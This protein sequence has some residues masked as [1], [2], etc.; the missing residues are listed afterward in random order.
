MPNKLKNHL[1]TKTHRLQL[2][3]LCFCVACIAYA[4]IIWNDFTYDDYLVIVNNPYIDRHGFI[5]RCFSKEYFNISGEATYRPVVT[6]VYWFVTALFGKQAMFFHILSLCL[7]ALTTAGIVLLGYSMGLGTFSILSGIFFAFHPVLTEAVC[8][9]AFMEDVLITFFS[10]IAMG[11]ITSVRNTDSKRKILIVHFFTAVCF[12]L[13]IFSKESGIGL[14]IL[15]PAGIILSG[16]KNK[17]L[18]DSETKVF[19]RQQILYIVIWMIPIILF[20]LVVRFYL[21]AGYATAPAWLGGSFVKACLNACVIAMEYLGRL[22]YPVS[23]SLIR[24]PINVYGFT[25]PVLIIA[26]LLHICLILSCL[27]TFRDVPVWSLG[28]TWFYV[29]FAPVSNLIPFWNPVADRYL[30]MMAVGFVFA[31]SILVKEL[32]RYNKTVKAITISVIVLISSTWIEH[33]VRRVS[34][35]Q[36]NQT[37]WKKELMLHPSNPVVLAENAA[38]ANQ[39]GNY[40]EAM[41]LT[42]KILAIDPNCK[43]ARYYMGKSL[44]MRKRYNEAL[45]HYRKVLS[46]QNLQKHLYCD[47]LFDVAYMADKVYGD[48]ELAEST[49]RRSL[50]LDP[51]YLRASF[52]LG[53]LLFR[54]GK[55]D[56]ALQVWR[57]ALKFCPSHPD[58]IHNLRLTERMLQNTK[59]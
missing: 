13:A 56:E 48:V 51:A 1:N 42:S 2:A 33:T 31:L 34:D 38:V 14:T 26:L 15:L 46:A 25:D 43:L 4:G 23:L 21:L 10:I 17:T 12:V 27:M 9:I 54:Q 32:W 57:S 30:Y 55:Y 59:K 53:E 28:I 37:L 52:N 11:L 7:H 16:I 19:L 18:S 40:E 47:A 35:W 22:V 36:N 45:P 3:F 5:S 8:S 39:N 20:Y 29:S 41:A 58:L 49:Y 6:L 44:L 50:A 24:T